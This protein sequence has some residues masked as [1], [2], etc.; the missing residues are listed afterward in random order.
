MLSAFFIVKHLITA[1]SDQQLELLPKKTNMVAS[2]NWEELY[3]Q[4]IEAN[5]PIRKSGDK[6]QNPD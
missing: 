2:K 5:S 1:S 4:E 6:L 3:C